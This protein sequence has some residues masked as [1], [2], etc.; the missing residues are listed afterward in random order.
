VAYVIAIRDAEAWS[1]HS[2]W[3]R[4]FKQPLSYQVPVDSV[5]AVTRLWWVGRGLA[6][7]QTLTAGSTSPSEIVFINTKDEPTVLLV[8]TPE[9]SGATPAAT[10]AASPV[11]TPEA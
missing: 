7:D 3:V 8:K 10:P 1:F 11:S 5:A 4:S 6:W 2:L 9:A